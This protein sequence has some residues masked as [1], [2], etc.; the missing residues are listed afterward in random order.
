MNYVD[1]LAQWYNTAL[2][3]GAAENRALRKIK[4]ERDQLELDVAAL[5]RQV[6]RLQYV[7]DQRAELIEHLR[8]RNTDLV[9]LTRT[10]KRRIDDLRIDIEGA[11]AII[12]KNDWRERSTL[13]VDLTILWN[14]LTGVINGAHP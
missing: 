14:T 13:D 1:V 3:A 11:R 7:C 6:A 5:T 12:P 4:H 9:E 8:V 10:L 2:A